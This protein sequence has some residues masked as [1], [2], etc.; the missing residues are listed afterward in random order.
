MRR[1]AAPVK[2]VHSISAPIEA[3]D[4]SGVETKVEIPRAAEA[5]PQTGFVEVVSKKARKRK[6]KSEKAETNSNAKA[7]EKTAPKA[8]KPK[9]APK[10]GDSELKT[11]AAHAGPKL[12]PQ[13]YSVSLLD[14]EGKH[15]YWGT[16]IGEWLHLPDHDRERVVFCGALDEQCRVT[17]PPKGNLH[18]V[19][20]IRRLVPSSY[21]T[22]QVWDGEGG[23]NA[24]RA[25]GFVSAAGSKEVA[26]SFA[27]VQTE[28][29][30]NGVREG[31]AVYS[32]EP[33]D[34]GLPVWV[35]TES[36]WKI[37]GVH[38]GS[39]KG[40]NVYRLTQSEVRKGLLGSG[41]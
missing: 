13:Q 22:K 36:G 23:V 11:E 35:L 5:E 28:L 17:L 39:K 20:P 38:E 25:V 18:L 15:I 24:V 12:P 40:R 19:G 3:L 7:Q 2:P 26:G 32:S 30:E 33:G 4:L 16:P 14:S 21:K 6:S 27:R 34:C 31:H 29:L 8:E 41:N 10:K 37:A 1:E 9:A